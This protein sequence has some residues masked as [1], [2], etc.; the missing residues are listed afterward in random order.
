MKIVITGFASTMSKPQRIAGYIYLPFHI[1]ILPLF[2]AMLLTYMP[3]G[4]DETTVNLLYYGMGFVF[5]LVVMW[6]YLRNA[7]DILLDNLATNIAAFFFGGVSYF[8]L[9]FLASGVLFAILGDQTTNPNNDAI[10]NMA[11]E[12]PRA[13]IALA[14]FIAPVVEEVL[15]RGVVFGSLAPKHRRLAFVVSIALFAL[16]HIWQYA[17]GTMDVTMFIYMIAYIPAGYALAWVY[18]KTSSIWAPIFLHMLINIISMLI[19]S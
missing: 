1:F 18:E 12:S 4:L 15:F 3:D 7:F 11:K 17:L 19:L 2:A 16:Y 9:S 10:L 13:V 6:Q 8:L 5:C 14:V